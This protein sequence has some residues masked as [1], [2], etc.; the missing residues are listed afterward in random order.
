MRRSWLAPILSLGLLASPTALAADPAPPPAAQV[1]IL[2]PR[3]IPS[4]DAAALRVQAEVLQASLLQRLGK[5][6][7]GQRAELRPEPER[8]CP[9]DRCERLTLGAL[10]LHRGQGCAVVATVHQPRGGAVRLAPWAGKLR[11]KAYQL[12]AGQRPEDFVT[13]EDFAPC[14]GLVEALAAGDAD[15][16]RE[17]RAGAAPAK[18]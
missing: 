11:L 8:R 9:H 2:W 15:V 18:P 12:Q 3:I 4:G 5:A 7:P 10:L 14:A 17:I 1:T 16:E 6:L 13:V